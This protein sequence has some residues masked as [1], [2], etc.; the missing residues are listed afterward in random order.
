[1]AIRTNGLMSK[2]CFLVACFN[3]LNPSRASGCISQEL[4][5][6][7]T[8]EGD[9]PPYSSFNAGACGQ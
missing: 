1:M 3:C 4:D 5:P 7:Q 9:K 2:C 8:F 6:A